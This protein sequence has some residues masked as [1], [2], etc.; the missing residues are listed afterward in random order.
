LLRR[1]LVGWSV[2]FAGQICLLKAAAAHALV[3]GVRNAGR[4][5]LPSAISSA[6]SPS[7][8]PAVIAGVS[9]RAISAVAC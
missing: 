3:Y 5:L 8:S 7:S 4:Q 9:S 1:H 6:R 2:S